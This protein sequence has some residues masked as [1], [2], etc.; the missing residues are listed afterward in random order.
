MFQ[1]GVSL[2]SL[3]ALLKYYSRGF[4]FLLAFHLVLPARLTNTVALLY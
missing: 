3:A 2:R 1:M 4:S